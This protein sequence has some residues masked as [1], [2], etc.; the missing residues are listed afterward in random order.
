MEE[1]PYRPIK[2]GYDLATTYHEKIVIINVMS[3]EEYEDQRSS[4]DDLPNEFS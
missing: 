1:A 2:V 3:R 4:R